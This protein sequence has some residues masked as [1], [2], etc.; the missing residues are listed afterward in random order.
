MAVKQG[1]DDGFFELLSCQIDKAS[2]NANCNSGGEDRRDD[3]WG[4]L[5]GCKSENFFPKPVGK[6]AVVKQVDSEGGGRHSI[7]E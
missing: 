6:D 3:P 4:V 5:V 2:G 1:D 7:D